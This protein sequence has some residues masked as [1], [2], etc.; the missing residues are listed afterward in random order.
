[1]KSATQDAFFSNNRVI[2]DTVVDKNAEIKGV[3]VTPVVGLVTSEAGVAATFTMVLDA[4]PTADVTIALSSDNIAEGVVIPASLIFTISDWNIPKSVTVV[5]ID[6]DV[7]DG[8]VLYHIVT[9]A[10]VSNDV[11]Y[12]GMAVADV[13]VTNSD[14]DVLPTLSVV[15]STPSTNESSGVS[16]L[17]TITRTGST[18]A[19]L[20]VHYLIDGSAVS[21]D[22]YIGVGLSVTIPMNSSSVLVPILPKNDVIVEGDESVTLTLVSD[23]SYVVSASN[24][25]FVTIIDD[26]Q[27]TTNDIGVEQGNSGGG[28]VMRPDWLLLLMGAYGLWRRGITGRR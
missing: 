27:P 1:V 15:A 9:G 10:A 21:G 6:D 17:F 11:N 16:A 24:T 23:V 4:A 19:A 14:N 2:E 8:D 7:I 25:A 20:T 3:T 28:G 13:A 18:A 26:E 12:S 5:G 22:D